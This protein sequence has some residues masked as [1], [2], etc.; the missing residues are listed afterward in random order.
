MVIGYHGNLTSLKEIGMVL[1]LPLHENTYVCHREN[2]V[3]LTTGNEQK[4]YTLSMFHTEPS[5]LRYQMPLGWE[6]NTE[7]CYYLN[8]KPLESPDQ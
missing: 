6:N 1:T 7:Y 5:F 2:A 8:P 4:R 3:A